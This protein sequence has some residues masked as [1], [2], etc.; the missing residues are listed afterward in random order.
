MVSTASRLPLELIVEVVRLLCGYGQSQSWSTKAEL[1]TY[2]L[3]CK[4]WAIIIRPFIFHDLSMEM[5]LDGRQFYALIISSH[6]SKWCIAQYVKRVTLRYSLSDIPWI[7]LV[8]M[9]KSWMVH[10]ENIDLIIQ[11]SVPN[12]SARRAPF[13][14]VHSHLPRGFPP[15][16]SGVNSLVLSDIDFGDFGELD[17]VFRSTPSPNWRFYRPGYI[18]LQR[19][20]VRNSSYIPPIALFN[21][22]IASPLTLS[23]KECTSPETFLRAIL[24]TEA[25]SKRTSNGSYPV[26]RLRALLTMEKLLDL[27]LKTPTPSSQHSLIEGIA[28]RNEAIR[29]QIVFT[30][31]KGVSC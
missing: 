24:P 2:S 13:R 9:C 23:V 14:S 4:Y 19:I 10:L 26:L 5:P 25:H 22:R 29:G 7:H 30:L 8:F 3:T 16:L 11:G 27:V 12:S 17:S 21:H 31:I 1:G 20:K 28:D 18:T 15:S 6:A